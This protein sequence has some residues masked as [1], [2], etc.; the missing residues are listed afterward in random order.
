M[1][2]TNRSVVI[3]GP[4]VARVFRIAGMLSHFKFRGAG[5]GTVNFQYSLVT[6]RL[7]WNHLIS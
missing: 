4:R 1:L 3:A 2:I 6:G 7:E 5:E